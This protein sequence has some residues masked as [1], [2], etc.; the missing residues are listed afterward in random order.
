MICNPACVFVSGNEQ[1]LFT[2]EGGTTLYNWCPKDYDL[3]DCFEFNILFTANDDVHAIQVIRRLLEWYITTLRQYKASRDP[4]NYDSKA[5]KFEKDR[6]ADTITYWLQ[7]LN[8]GKAAPV[9]VENNQVFRV[10][11]ASNDTFT[12]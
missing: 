5:S 2:Y 4:Y 10:G 12:H 1:A 9:V 11:W 3:S 8:L 6:K 7:A